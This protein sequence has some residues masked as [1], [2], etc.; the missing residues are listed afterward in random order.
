MV[1]DSTRHY[2][3]L[4]IYDKCNKWTTNILVSV[5]STHL[6]PQLV[7]SQ[8]NNFS[9]KYIENIDWFTSIYIYHKYR[10]LKTYVYYVHYESFKVA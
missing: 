7:I 4:Y 2:I 6:R 1:D 5:Y 8:F 9:K 10:I 3:I